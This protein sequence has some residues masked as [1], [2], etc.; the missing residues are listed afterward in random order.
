MYNKHPWQ[1]HA[2]KYHP[3]KQHPWQAGPAGPAS[4]PPALQSS[5]PTPLNAPVVPRV[6]DDSGKEIIEIEDDEEPAGPATRSPEER[7]QKTNPGD[8]FTWTD[9]EVKTIM[10]WMVKNQ[11]IRSIDSMDEFEKLLDELGFKDSSISDDNKWLLKKKTQQKLTG[12]EDRLTYAGAL[13]VL[14]TKWHNPGHIREGIKPEFAAYTKAWLEPDWDGKITKPRVASA[15]GTPVLPKKNR[16]ILNMKG[17]EQ[18]EMS[19]GV[20][21]TEDGFRKEGLRVTLRDRKPVKYYEDPSD[22]FDN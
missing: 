9:E 6:A 22:E 14:E 12:L 7:L 10:R 17:Q 19:E 5:S 15:V 1:Y 18:E 16:I 2:W 11:C 20:S 8:K 21:P 13:K 3:W 4:Q